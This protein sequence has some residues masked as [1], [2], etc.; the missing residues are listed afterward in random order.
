MP[1][2]SDAANMKP[3]LASK[4]ENRAVARKP[5]DAVAVLLGLKFADNIHFKFQSSHASK[6][7]LQSSKHT[8]AKQNLTQN[9]HSRSFK[10]TCF[11]VS[12]KPIRD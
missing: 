11:G 9:D 1:K 10:V 4:Q 2:N 5:R 6:A 12:E 3:H 8:G 7:R